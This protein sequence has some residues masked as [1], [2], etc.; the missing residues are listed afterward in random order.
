[1]QC[2]VCGAKTIVDYREVSSVRFFECEACE[3]LFADP[4]FLAEIEAGE[5][6]NYECD[7]WREEVAAARERSFG[8]SL[9][10]V[11]ET[12]LYCR[13]P[14]RN[15]IDIGSGPGFL[16]DA[17]AM[18][19]PASSGMFH[20][21]EMFPPAEG[22]R[23]RQ[24]NYRIGPVGDMPLMFEAGCC[25]EV[26]EHLT[27]S[28]LRGL[29]RQLATRSVVGATYYFGSGRPA[30]V[31]NEDPDYLDPLRRGHI[32]S[33]AIKGLAPLFAEH[34]FSIIP[35]PG[36]EW[37]FLAEYGASTQCSAEE[38]LGRIWTADAEN[39]ERLKD[40]VFGPLMY[41]MGIES[42]RCYLEHAVCL[43]RT[44]WAFQLDAQLGSAREA[45]A[46]AEQQSRELSLR[47]A[48]DANAA[49]VRRARSWLR[50]RFQ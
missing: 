41:S 2:P 1:L 14:I 22:Y 50:R 3:C 6:K 15:F 36:R 38:L 45:L 39:V 37:A 21:A 12:F 13:I 4:S 27:P 42:A 31:K 8:S 23:T 7:Y 24:P 19:M 17:L 47:L 29:V 9:Q 33:Y 30:Y 16:L 18:L 10:R 28:M 32:V 48:S 40:P 34:G 20:A 44:E 49:D 11:A 26:I 25:I 35:L 46:T 43:Q 5:V